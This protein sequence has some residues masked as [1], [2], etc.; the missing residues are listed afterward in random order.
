MLTT[1]SKNKPTRSLV[2]A[3]ECTLFERNHFMNF[4]SKRSSTGHVLLPAHDPGSQVRVDLT[5]GVS[6]QYNFLSWTLGRGS[7]VS[8]FCS[9]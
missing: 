7:V 5:P 3:S 2:S 1:F 8:I 4:N 9:C 6:G